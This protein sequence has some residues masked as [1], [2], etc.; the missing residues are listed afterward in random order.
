MTRWNF[1]S[2]NWRSGYFALRSS[3]R[4]SERI[5]GLM[6]A[7]PLLGGDD[8]TTF[9]GAAGGDSGGEDSVGDGGDFAGWDAVFP[10]DCENG[11]ELLDFFFFL[12]LFAMPGV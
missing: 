1:S 11:R 6:L 5:N 8:L 4:G 10:P 12:V 3:E 9:V 2:A 7:S